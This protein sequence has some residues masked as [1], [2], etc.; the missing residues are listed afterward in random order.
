MPYDA[1]DLST[2]QHPPTSCD[3][4]WH[5]S[6][7]RAAVVV[8]VRRQR[9]CYSRQRYRVVA[10]V[11]AAEFVSAVVVVVDDD[12]YRYCWWRCVDVSRSV[13]DFSVVVDCREFC[14]YVSRYSAT[15]HHQRRRSYFA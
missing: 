4:Q 13:D 9:L 1:I 7:Y 6:W 10:A 8:V 15:L 14:Y 12:D 5:A 2:T 3:D 11:A